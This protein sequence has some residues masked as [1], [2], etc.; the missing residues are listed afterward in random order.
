[1]SHFKFLSAA[2]SALLISAALV[3][4]CAG[5]AAAA[6]PCAGSDLYIA[7]HEDDT[8]LFES[9]D[10]LEDVGSNRC[11]RTIFLT[12]GDA[13]KGT[14]YWEGREAG[15]EA[16]YAEMAGV[17]DLWTDS[18]TT[19]AGHP[20]HLA[21]LAARPGI[22]ILYL[23]LPDGGVEGEGFPSH[24][25]QSLRK[26]WNGGNSMTPA[27]AEI[28]AVDGSTRY[29]YAGLIEALTAA[30]EA[31]GAHQIATQNYAATLPG[32]DHADHVMTGR[33]SRSGAEAL[34]GS[35]LGHRLDSFESY[36]VT[37]RPANVAGALLAAKKGVF[38]AYVPFDTACGID[39]DCG[40]APYPEWLER[41]Y[42]AASVTKGAVADAG[43]EQ[44]AGPG[45]TVRLDG[46][47]SSREGGGAL[48]YSWSQVGG[49]PVSLAGATTV[50]PTLTTPSRPALLTF[51]LTVSGGGK[52]SAPDFVRVR[53]PPATPGPVAIAGPDQSVAAATPVVL[54]GSASYDP[55]S[56]PLTYAWTQT[57]G[58]PVSLVG[59]DSATP[60]F[61]APDGPATTLGFSLV[62]SN[63]S[64]ASA[65]ATVRVAVAQGALPPPP[66][67]TPGK[68][69]AGPGE[70]AAPARLAT[71]Q[72]K[73][74]AGRSSRRVIHVR[75]GK[76]D[77]C[78]GRLPQG[79]RCRVD[80]RGDVVLE[81]RRSLKRRGRFRLTVFLSNGVQSIKRPLLVVIKG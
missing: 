19:V 39:E 6:A 29:T 33:F 10:L 24:G 8:I 47:G 73:F 22:T 27:I 54:D 42:V 59:A 16:A 57:A 52:A 46:G 64:E 28:E 55:E 58:T 36:E 4:S 31:S 45:A 12:A 66:P 62:V 77:A 2:G 44:R 41:Q 76:A 71:T 74:R 80:R 69:G 26:L 78:R 1:V 9:P 53:V 38:D 75:E 15:A 70:T 60:R 20:V 72:V 14:A 63:G 21:T 49:P 48:S 3:L 5:T 61:L 35:F 13:G 17:A 40:A 18:T 79:A 11:V 68:P 43:L 23:R 34:P 56:Q 65:A 32:P 81:T 7:A 50:E 67:R 30:M 25:N 37:V 51:A